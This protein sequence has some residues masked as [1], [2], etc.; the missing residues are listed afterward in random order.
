MEY[1]TL[2]FDQLRTLHRDIGA[3]IA[4][5]RQ[6][7][8]EQLRERA[9]LLGFTADDLVV[10]K[11]TRK[12]N[13]ARKYQDPENPENTWGGKGPKPAWLTDAL[14]NGAALEEFAV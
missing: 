5:R 2:P 12:Q 6:E 10:K 7:E 13:G 3:L 14:E 9:A 1:Q 4:K 11:S 8:L